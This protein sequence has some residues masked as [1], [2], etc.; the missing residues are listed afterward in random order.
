M[1]PIRIIRGDVPLL[2]LNMAANLSL[3][4]VE[5]ILKMAR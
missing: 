1:S 5:A 4:S 3:A 2:I